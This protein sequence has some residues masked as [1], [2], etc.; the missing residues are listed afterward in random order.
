MILPIGAL[1]SGQLEEFFRDGLKND[2][3]M[4]AFDFDAPPFDT[5]WFRVG[6]GA[7]T[8]GPSMSGNNR[9]VV[10]QVW[11]DT[12]PGSEGGIQRV[13]QTL[14]GI[15]WQRAWHSGVAGSWREIDMA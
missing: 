10:E 2:G 8:H 11:Y 1:I 15:M 4:P 12:S 13:T 5:G 3:A 6:S 7:H 9:I 14:T